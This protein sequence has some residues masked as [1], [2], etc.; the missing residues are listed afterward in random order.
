MMTVYN[1]FK[2]SVA[3]RSAT[4]VLGIFLLTTS[5]MLPQGDRTERLQERVTSS[6]TGLDISRHNTP[7][8]INSLAQQAL[9]KAQNRVEHAKAQVAQ[10]KAGLA[11][12]RKR[13]YHSGTDQIKAEEALVKAASMELHAA[14]FNLRDAKEAAQLEEQR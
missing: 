6:D 5:T 7:P 14:C 9:R 11:Q 3:R 13:G 4:M 10:A 2:R 8:P 1:L 12:A